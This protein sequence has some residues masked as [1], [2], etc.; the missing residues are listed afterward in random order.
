MRKRA[1]LCQL[2]DKA[3]LGKARPGSSAGGTLGFA[4]SLFPRKKPDPQTPSPVPFRPGEIE[5]VG[6]EPKKAAAPEPESSGPGPVIRGRRPRRAT[7]P[8]SRPISFSEVKDGPDGSGPLEPLK[9]GRTETRPELDPDE[10]VR[11]LSPAR[12]ERS[13]SPGLPI[14]IES[15][16]PDLD[17][18]PKPE[19]PLADTAEIPVEEQGE[20]SPVKSFLV[21][22]VVEEEAERSRRQEIRRQR[23]AERQKKEEEE[24]QRRLRSQTRRQR[25][26]ERIRRWR[27]DRKVRRERKLKARADQMLRSSAGEKSKRGWRERMPFRAAAE[28][29]KQFSF[30]DIEFVRRVRG[31]LRQRRA[32]RARKMWSDVVG[33][34]IG[35]STIRAAYFHD[36]Q[37]LLFEKK[38]PEGIIVDG[39]LAEP[40]EL[41][42]ELR[43]LWREG[44]IPSTKVNF[45]ISN[46]LVAV[47]AISLPAEYEEDIEQALALNAA[48]IVAPMNPDE[49]IIDYAELSRTGPQVSLQV[50]AADIK[51]SR[52]FM[53]AVEGAGLL[54]ASAEV[55]SLAA[56]RSM[57]VPRSPHQTHG[58]IDIGAEETTIN[59]AS[60]PDTFFFR[61]VESGGN[62]FTRALGS[63]DLSWAEAEQ[64]KKSSGIGRRPVDPEIDAGDFALLRSAMQPVADN[65]CQEIFQTQEIYEK[66]ETGRRKPVAG[67]TII[68]GG[69]KL[70]ALADQIAAATGRPCDLE[71]TPWPGLEA[72][73]VDFSLW[74]SAIGLGRSNSMSLLPPASKLLER[75]RRR[76]SKISPAQARSRAKEMSAGASQPWISAKILA[77]LLVALALLGMFLWG[78]RISSGTEDIR[79]Q[80]NLE[81]EAA[82]RLANGSGAALARKVEAELKGKP[83]WSRVARISSGIPFTE[84]QSNGSDVVL[85]GGNPGS[86]ELPPGVSR[87]DLNRSI[88]EITIRRRP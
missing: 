5:I 10:P 48:P 33:L 11:P 47:R 79:Q 55:G 56:C 9:P 69:A 81:N 36:G 76:H 75:N 3:V 68:G 13:E 17:L 8:R 66:S 40:E 31:I 51:M 63:F 80:A 87:K 54:A 23:Q 64:L 73:D 50:A 4:M 28:E 45:S 18:T 53:E 65:L 26:N 70:Q 16:E 22:S 15:A 7:P 52:T 59:I 41:S 57:V 62:D 43:Q 44:E 38:I 27:E 21:G 37:A 58:I 77:V 85:T 82:A 14:E 25:R 30:S 6:E 86:I 60:G 88:T 78:Q 20:T 61:T 19:V 46:R 67:Y 2:L 34:D 29:K 83:D 49:T 42:E 12:T 39:L 24:R 74:A 1:E 71:L 35:A 84:I 32:D 72:I